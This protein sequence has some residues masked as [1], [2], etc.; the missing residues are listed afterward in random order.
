MP[1]D[2]NLSL[3]PPLPDEEAWT[4]EAEKLYDQGLISAEGARLRSGIPVA[5]QAIKDVG[6]SAT[7]QTAQLELVTES[8]EP[9]PDARREAK[10]KD[11]P[12]A[13]TAKAKADRDKGEGLK[14]KTPPEWTP[15][16]T[17]PAPDAPIDKDQA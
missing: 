1:H 13:T 12:P 5:E 8:H 16:L 9:Q 10:L 14:H 2:P 4:S 15:H 11:R 6:G 7:S 17:V 3:V